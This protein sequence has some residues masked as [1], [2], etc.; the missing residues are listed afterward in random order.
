MKP[1]L[2]FLCLILLCWS[3]GQVSGEFEKSVYFSSILNNE[4]T[5]KWFNP[6]FDQYISLFDLILNDRNQSIGLECQ[7][8]LKIIR[9]DLIKKEEWALKCKLIHIDYNQS[10]FKFNSFNLIE[11]IVQTMNQMEHQKKVSLTDTIM[12][13]A[14]LSFALQS[15]HP[16]WSNHQTALGHNSVWFPFKPG[17]LRTWKRSQLTRMQWEGCSRMQNP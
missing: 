4:N 11:L 6:G 17:I 2:S 14:N 5:F 12:I 7:K 9:R 15:N 13:W 1:V 8:S 3:L 10:A 16:I